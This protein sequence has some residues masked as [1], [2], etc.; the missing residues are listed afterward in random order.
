[1]IREILKMG[2]A[3]LLRV[4]QPVVNRV[5]SKAANIGPAAATPRRQT[6]SLIRSAFG[7]LTMIP[8]PKGKT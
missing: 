1:M 8:S 3:R 2:D 6:P 5:D 4:A 7:P